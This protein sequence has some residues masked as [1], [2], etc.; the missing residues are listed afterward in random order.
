VV[1]DRSRRGGGVRRLELDALDE[2]LSFPL[3]YGYAA[4]G[5][6]ADVGTELSEEWLG[7]SVFGFAPHGTHF[8]ATPDDLRTVP[9][10]VSP[11]AAT[12]LPSS[13]TATNLVLDG[14][15]RVGERVVVFGAG[16]IGLCT[17]HLLSSF[18]LGDLV[19]VDP[20]AERRELAESLGADAAVEPAALEATVDGWDGDGADLMYELSGQPETLDDA[21]EV[22]GYDSRVIVGSWYGTK[23]APLDLGGRFHRDRITVE[24]SQVSTLD[25]ELRGRWDKQRRL[26]TAMDALRD[27]PVERVISH[28]IPFANAP[29][30]YRLLDENPED[31]LQV[32]LTY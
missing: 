12:L 32:L 16:V 25:P 11:A 8:T 29:R 18:P 9:E 7:E 17:T 27:V 30:A 19:V 1:A 10:D 5:E 31:A 24:S 20:I 2:D 4:V 26:R 22:A 28:R 15:P 6:V 13:E 3:R 23:R 14:R 21:L